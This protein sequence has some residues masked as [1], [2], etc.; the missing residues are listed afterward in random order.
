MYLVRN[1]WRNRAEFRINFLI[2]VL[3]GLSCADV[4]QSKKTKFRY[5]HY[6]SR[7]EDIFENFTRIQAKGSEKDGYFTNTWA[8]E[9][10]DPA[11]ERDVAR[12]ARKHG[13]IVLDKV[14]LCL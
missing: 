14:S 4:A 12:I 5:S 1:R 13:F 9:L 2:F 3:L 6:K 8:V 10:H 11:E 7:L